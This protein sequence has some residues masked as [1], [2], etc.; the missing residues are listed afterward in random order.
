MT[1]FQQSVR[2]YVKYILA[3][4]WK[5]ATPQD[6]FSAVSLALRERLIDT[7]LA[8]ERQYSQ[9]DRKRIYY[10]SMEFLMGRSLDARMYK[11]NVLEG[12]ETIFGFRTLRDD[13]V[14]LRE[15]VRDAPGLEWRTTSR[16]SLT[17]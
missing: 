13:Q 16:L 7:H 11:S 15:E 17:R 9:E 12:N 1:D 3:K 10:L 4:Q 5:Y 2:H 14:I 6:L 8:N